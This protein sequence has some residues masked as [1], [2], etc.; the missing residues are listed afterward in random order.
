MY[1]EQK[2]TQIETRNSAALFNHE[3]GSFAVGKVN[4]APGSDGRNIEIAHILELARSI[5]PNSPFLLAGEQI[6]SSPIAQ[7]LAA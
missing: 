2:S 3:R 1:W 7:K 6:L 5:K 4:V